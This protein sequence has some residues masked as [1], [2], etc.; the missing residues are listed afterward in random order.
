[1]YIHVGVLVCLA[2]GMRTKITASET[3]KKK[4]KNREKSKKKMKI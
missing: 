2:A 4:E 1:M 3:E